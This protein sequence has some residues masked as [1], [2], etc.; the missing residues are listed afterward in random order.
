MLSRRTE[1]TL[2]I[3]AIVVLTAVF[4]LMLNRTCRVRAEGDI[5][6]SLRIFNT[7]LNLVRNEYVEPQDPEKL[8]YGAIDGMLATLDDPYTRLLRPKDFKEMQVETTGKFGGIG[9]YITIRNERL[10]VESPIAGTPASRAGIRAYD[11]IVS[12]DGKPTKG[13]S[14]DEAVSRLRGKVGTKVTIG[15]MR[16]GFREPVEY[17]LV[18]DEI[19][20]RSVV[21]EVMKE[22]GFGY[23]RI[24]QFGEETAP[25]LERILRSYQERGVPGIVL[26]LR[27][28]PGGLLLAAWKVADLFLD[29]GMIVYTK[30]RQPEHNQEFRAQPG[31]YLRGVPIVVLVDRGSASAAEIVTGALK[32]R[33]RATVVGEKTFGKGVVQTV[34]PLGED[35]ALS[36]T[37]A[38]YY[39]PAGTQIH[40]TGIQPDIEVKAPEPS[41]EEMKAVKALWESGRIPEFVKTHPN[42]TDTDLEDFRRR[43]SRTNIVLPFN[44]LRRLVRAEAYRNDEIVYDL[45]DD[46]QLVRAVEVLAAAA[47]RRR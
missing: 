1:R 9:I 3:T 42:F 26:D 19:K 6:G 36:F 20:I 25:D 22:N 31:A 16:E 29:D 12:I 39:T 15:I 10:V 13:L 44:L 34:R 46:P 32:D 38:K 2:W 47:D 40:K 21:A 28:N 33:G 8:V 14:L 18:R 45:Q 5:Y 43:L 17:T 35:M 37:T 4:T 7:V 27:S 24:K 30:G 41:E 23:I 11:E